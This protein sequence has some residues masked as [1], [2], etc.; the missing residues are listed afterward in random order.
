MVDDANPD[1][2]EATDAE[3]GADADAEDAWTAEPEAKKNTVMIAQIALVVAVLV[4]VAIVLVAKSGKDD[5]NKSSSSATTTTLA[6]TPGTDA[7][8]KPAKPAWPAAVQGRPP[9]LGKR[10][11]KAPDVKSTA[12]PG[13]YAWSDFDGWHVWV[14]PGAGVPQTVTGTLTSNDPFARADAAR[15]GAG[16]VTVNGKTVDFNLKTDQGVNGVDFNTGFY[17]K[18]IVVIVND[19]DGKAL[20]PKLFKTGSK[21]VPAVYPLVIEKA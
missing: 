18:R 2:V 9:A 10:G 3:T 8:G 20:D 6:G 12:K 16:D 11:E 14:V 1:E 5:D 19:P 21:S 13:V 7:S 17:G 15:P 4:V